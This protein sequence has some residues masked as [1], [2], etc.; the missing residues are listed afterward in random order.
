MEKPWTLLVSDKGEC[1]DDPKEEFWG[2]ASIPFL[3]LWI[4][5]LS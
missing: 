5:L 2:E 3:V 4:C 1:G